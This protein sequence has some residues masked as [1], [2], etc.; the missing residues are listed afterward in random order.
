MA[1]ESPSIVVSTSDQL[2][3]TAATQPSV[4]VEHTSLAVI[5]DYILSPDVI[6]ETIRPTSPTSL[7]NSNSQWHNS[8]ELMGLSKAFPVRLQSRPTTSLSSYSV[9]ITNGAGAGTPALATTATST[10]TVT[11]AATSSLS[12]A[13]SDSS[14]NKLSTD[15]CRSQLQASATSLPNIKSL[16]GRILRDNNL[17]GWPHKSTFN[18]SFIE[19]DVDDDSV[20]VFDDY[21]IDNDVDDRSRDELER[22][23]SQKKQ[24]F[25]LSYAGKPIFSMHGNDDLISL[26]MGIIQA[27]VSGFEQHSDDSPLDNNRDAL[28][29]FTAGTTSFAVTVEDPLILVAISKLGETEGQLRTQLDA[30]HTQLLSA[31]TKAQIVKVFN[32]RTNFDLRK[33]M[34]GAETFLHSLTRE[35]AFGS[36]AILLNAIECLRLRNSVRDRINVSLL[37]GRTPSL[38]YGL[39][40]AD[41]RLVSVIRPKRHSLHPPDLQVIFSMLFHNATFHDGREHWIPICLP[42]FNNRGFLHAYIVFFRPKTA[43]V[44]ISANRDAFYELRKAKEDILEN[45]TEENC[46]APIDMAVNLGR[47]R[48]ADFGAPAIQH[49]LYK[50]RSNVQFTMPNF[51]PHFPDRKAQHELMCLYRRL[52]AAIHTKHTHLKVLY[53]SRGSAVALAWATHSFEVYCVASE[54]TS[55]AIL[56]QGMDTIIAWIKREESRLFISNGA[57]F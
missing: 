52:H 41:G 1:A 20:T 51:E 43:L 4:P 28:R 54:Q 16:L 37:K 21:N 8:S 22:F 44:L 11:A 29:F 46:I 35:M 32:G 45:F 10:A 38:L 25:L 9:P 13:S 50:S 23:L 53:I 2:A 57:V 6:E 27:L 19:T 17:S 18:N 34:D 14:V 48:T 40:L 33:L 56:A 55:K 49:F 3:I 12:T 36:P 15:T 30:L 31:L 26:H 47:Y 7:L 24:Y 5:D 39:V 42:K